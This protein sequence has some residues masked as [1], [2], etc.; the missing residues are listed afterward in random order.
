MTAVKGENKVYCFSEGEFSVL[1]DACRLRRFLCFESLRGGGTIE[2]LSRRDYFQVVYELGKSGILRLDGDEL[3]METAVSDMFVIC[4]EC[5]AV[6]CFYKEEDSRYTAC[7][8][9]GK[10]GRFTLILSGSR[11]EEYVRMSLH[12]K[13]EFEEISRTYIEESRGIRIFSGDGTKVLEECSTESG[14]DGEDVSAKILNMMQKYRVIMG[15]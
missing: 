6:A 2:K 7:L 15:E 4:R 10:D 3:I 5:T 13:E 9:M 12:E 14:K 8:Y 1:A 11:T